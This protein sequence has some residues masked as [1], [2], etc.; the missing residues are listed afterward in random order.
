MSCDQIVEDWLTP[1][2]GSRQLHAAVPCKWAE[3]RGSAQ[4]IG[5]NHA[6]TTART[7]ETPQLLLVDLRRSH[8]DPQNRLTTTRKTCCFNPPME[9]CLERKKKT[10]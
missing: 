6:N 3:D 7:L 9:I 1:I 5:L 8:H 4:L 2:G 10:V